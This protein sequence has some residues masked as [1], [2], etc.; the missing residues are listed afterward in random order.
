MDYTWKR[1][2]TRSLVDASLE[3]RLNLHQEQ[4][5]DVYAA[6]WW[7]ILIGLRQSSIDN[8]VATLGSDLMRDLLI[9][10]D[11]GLEDRASKEEL[12]YISCFARPRLLRIL[13]E[14]SFAPL[15]VSLSAG[16]LTEVE[17]LNFEAKPHARAKPDIEVAAGTVLTAVID[18]GIAF[19]HNLFRSSLL[20]SRV[21]FANVLATPSTD[22]GPA[23]SAG[24]VLKQSE[25]DRLLKQN[26]HHKLLDEEQF[27]RYAGLF[28]AS[29]TEFSSTALS[30]SHGAHVTGL[31]AGYPMDVAP[32][33]RP[34]L[35]ALLPSLVTQDSTG[36]NL[37]PSLA[38][39]LKRLTKQASRFVLPDGTRPPVVFNFSY[40]NFSGP[41][42]GTSAIEHEFERYFGREGDQL[43]R[44][45][46]PEGNGN[47]SRTHGKIRFDTGPRYFD[48]LV[49]PDD[50]TSSFVEMWLPFAGA[51]PTVNLVGVTVTAPVG[52][53]SGPVTVSGDYDQVLC[54][55]NGVE[56]ARL[57]YRF[58]SWPTQRGVIT[59]SM[60]AT[61]S[62]EPKPLAPS[63]QWRIDINPLEIGLDDCVETWIA[64]DETIPGFRP[65]GKQSYFN[66][67]DY[68]RFNRLGAPL[69]VDPPDSESPVRRAGSQSGIT[70]SAAP[71]VIAGFVES[72]RLIADYSAAGPVTPIR[73]AK[74]AERVGPDAAAKSDANPALSGVLSAGTR[75]GSMARQNG[76][77][78]A[79][80]RVARMVVDA[81]AQGASGNRKWLW[82]EAA[83]DARSSEEQPSVTRTGGGQLDI[84]VS[85]DRQ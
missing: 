2:K 57:S 5:P 64:R 4:F 25:I 27:Y 20:R 51:E 65:G 72:N 38:L 74:H 45:V 37:M 24:R 83:S 59:L 70:T 33:D 40:G 76:T 60:R 7:S 61:A 17:H 23:I 41:H 47:Q 63:G 68:V 73:D 54:D 8:F 43:R 16:M 44:L 3:F 29:E 39:A 71:L 13:N 6:A 19:A 26:T 15:V 28:E 84:P 50:R 1:E 46:L 36:Q 80:P 32:E 82:E 67:A 69:P 21:A 85:F 53:P 42:D 14:G 75:S 81:M 30:Q 11:Y 58:A 77:S 18:D 49:Q 79:A 62:L 10:D 22:V 66:N 55:R 31:A 35:C 12:Q 9:P 78:V 48:L 56:V 34:I 52:K